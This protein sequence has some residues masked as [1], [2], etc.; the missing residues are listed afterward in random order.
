MTINTIMSNFKPIEGLAKPIGTTEPK[1]EGIKGKNNFSEMLGDALKE[2]DT[3]QKT[4]DKQIEGIVLGSD[5]VSPHG[6]MIA[7]EKAD[8]AFQ[9]MNSVRSK[10]IRAYEEIIR[11][12]V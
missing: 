3:L 10:I 2:V 6:A 7:L 9:M 1:T 12:Q 4:A 11:T 5:N 8:M